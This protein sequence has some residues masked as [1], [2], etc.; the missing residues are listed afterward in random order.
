[1]IK[2]VKNAKGIDKKSRRK[3]MK[4]GVKKESG[5]TLVALGITIIFYYDYFLI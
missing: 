1:M 4:K 2:E 3:Q 5:V